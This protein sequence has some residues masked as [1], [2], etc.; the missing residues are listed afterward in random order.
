MRKI[1]IILI[2]SF[3]L[4]SC[5]TSKNPKKLNAEFIDAWGPKKLSLRNPVDN[6]GI[7]EGKIYYWTEK[8]DEMYLNF[9][10][11]KGK[12]VRQL[13]FK[14]GRGPG[15]IFS[16]NA[17]FIQND[18]INVLDMQRRTLLIFDMKGHFIDNYEININDFGTVARNKNNLYFSGILKN[19]IAKIDLK[20]NKILKTIKYKNAD[21]IKSFRD[22]IG[23]KLRMSPLCIDQK[24]NMVYRSSYNLPYRIEKYDKKLKKV[25][26]FKRNIEGNFKDFKITAG[27][28]SSGS[29]M[30]SNMKI[31]KEY[32]YASFGGGQVAERKDN[33][34]SL[35]GIPNKYFIS[36]FD[37]KNG[38]FV[39]EIDVNAISP[40]KGVTKL[41][42]VT[43][44]KLYIFVMDFE[45]TLDKILANKKIDNE[46]SEMES[47]ILA[48]E[49]K[50][51]IVI[52]D[53]PI[54]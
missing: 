47:R 1:V 20:N 12:K 52:V 53:N 40:L 29:I 17:T 30:V 22:I 41:L 3:I 21:K 28:G 31:D 37:K 5:S 54:Y 6:I 23:K 49:V 48:G 34:I 10:S 43:Q 25:D 35:S 11:L 26:E 16:N 39:Y 18:K 50:R 8:G 38:E 36:V 15:Q 33:K 2:L 13:K 4:F 9:Y 7:Y 19:K 51:A 24:N 32:L 46:K 45:N 44:D 42:K 27:S 14:V